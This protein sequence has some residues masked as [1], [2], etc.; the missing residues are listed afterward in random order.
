MVTH[1]VK[2]I[3]LLEALSRIVTISKKLIKYSS[4]TCFSF[5]APKE[6]KNFQKSLLS[7]NCHEW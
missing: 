2:I 1:K 7:I 4:P 3:P 5:S 6:G